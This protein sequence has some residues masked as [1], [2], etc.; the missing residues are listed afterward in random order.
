M[1]F[2][3]KLS[4]SFPHSALFKCNQNK[5]ITLAVMDVVTVCF[6]LSNY[7]YFVDKAHLVIYLLY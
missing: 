5:F 1:L 6:I 4:K 2:T 3:V 7:K